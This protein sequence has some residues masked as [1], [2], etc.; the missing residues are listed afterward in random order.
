MSERWLNG[1]E[2]LH[3]PKKDWQKEDVKPDTAE[4][5]RECVKKK[6]VGVVISG[7]AGIQNGIKCKDYSSWKRIVRITAWVLKFKNAMLTKIRRSQEEKSVNEESV[8]PKDL[9][10]SR[11]LWIKECLKKNKFRT[12]SPFTDEEGIIR[13]GGQCI[14]FIREKTSS[15]TAV[16]TQSFPIDNGRS[17][18]KGAFGCC[19]YSSKNQKT[20]LDR[21][22]TRPNENDQVQ[23]R[24]L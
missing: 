2:F 7:E 16:R 19:N 17:T 13:V 9:E 4:V 14:G 22:G 10:E 11:K 15:V 5:E 6:T 23:L 18:S 21:Q 12:L 24:R 8:T 3:R 20:V 1:P